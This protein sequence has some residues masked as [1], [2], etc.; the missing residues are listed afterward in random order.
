MRPAGSRSGSRRDGFDDD[1][2]L[3]E[4]LQME[5]HIVEEGQAGQNGFA[6]PRRQGEDFR[7]RRC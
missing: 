3:A 4:G 6:L 2:V 5:T 1:G 7:I